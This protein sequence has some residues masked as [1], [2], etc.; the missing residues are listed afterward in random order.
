MTR[1]RTST[2]RKQ[3]LAIFRAALAAADPAKAVAAHLEGLD[4][5][6]FRNIYV[7]GA[8]KAGASMAQAA[9]RT[10]SGACQTQCAAEEMARMAAELQELVRNFRHHADFSAPSQPIRAPRFRNWRDCRSTPPAMRR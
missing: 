7:I 2:L 8:G 1:T 3:A 4:V 9:E 5:S 6:R 10:G